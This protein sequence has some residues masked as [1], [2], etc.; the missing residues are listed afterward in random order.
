MTKRWTATRSGIQPKRLASKQRRAKD[1]DA[2]TDAAEDAIRA[3]RKQREWL[4]AEVGDEAAAAIL[5]AVDQLSGG[6]VD[7]ALIQRGRR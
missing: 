1:R 3:A 2:E 5:G 4:R 7:I 6:L